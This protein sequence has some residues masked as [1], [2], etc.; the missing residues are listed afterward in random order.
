MWAYSWP[1]STWGVFTWMQ[2]VSDR[3][4]L[5]LYAT[6]Q[7]VGL[8]AVVFQLGYTPIA[9]F[10]NLAVAFISPILYARAGDA[11]SANRNQDVHR[12]IWRIAFVALGLTAVAV[13]FAAML[14]RPIL[15]LLVAEEYRELSYL[16]PWVILA[17]GVFASGQMVALKLMSD[18][19]SRELLV[20]KIA[21][22]LIGLAL[23]LVG[24]VVA[25]TYGVVA[26]MVAFSTIYLT[27]IILLARGAGL[28]LRETECMGS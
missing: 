18:L 26:A 11:R 25:G 17:G 15:L 10:L 22:A 24:A 5:G 20:P 19:K 1:F 7:D 16:L 27:W 21:T 12:I 13:G 4:A 6:V 28:G 9:L 8:Y 3:W 2:Q 14:H 23:N